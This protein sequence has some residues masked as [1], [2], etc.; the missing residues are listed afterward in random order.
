LYVTG[1]VQ[2]LAGA[3]SRL[4]WKLEPASEEVKLNVA[5]VDAT[6]ADGPPVIV[7]FGVE[8][9]TENT[10][11][12]TKCVLFRLSLRP[13]WPWFEPAKPGHGRAS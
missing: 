1:D 2:A 7:V 5:L 13:H 3:E 12:V 10:G 9:S 4:H 6:T 11:R 8:V